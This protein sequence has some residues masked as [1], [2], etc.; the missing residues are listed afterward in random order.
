MVLSIIL[1][2][3]AAII[4]LTDWN[5]NTHSESRSRIPEIKAIDM[6]EIARKVRL[7]RERREAKQQPVLEH[8][9]AERAKLVQE[10]EERL[11]KVTD[12]SKRLAI[13]AEWS[14]A[15]RLVKQ[16]ASI[17]FSRDLVSSVVCKHNL[18]T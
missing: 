4:L 10:F 3:L 8:L 16:E 2:F 18:I 7:A 1:V 6:D 5:A 15:W 14:E 17:K 11:S 9:Q 12:R 13:T